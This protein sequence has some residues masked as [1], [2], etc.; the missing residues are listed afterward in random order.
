MAARHDR[1]ARRVGTAMIAV[2][3]V[4][5]SPADEAIV[6]ALTGGLSAP[7]AVVQGPT[8]T[9]LGAALV[10]AGIGLRTYG[11]TS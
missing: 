7:L 2:G 10:V 3:A 4:I 8:T 9:A 11:A 5:A 6:L 1:T